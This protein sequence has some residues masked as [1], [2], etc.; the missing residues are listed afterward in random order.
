MIRILA[1]NHE[2]P[3]IQ[4]IDAQLAKHDTVGNWNCIELM[5]SKSASLLHPILKVRIAQRMFSFVDRL[6]RA[7]YQEA[8]W[9]DLTN[10]EQEGWVGRIDLQLKLVSWQYLKSHQSYILIPT[11]R[12]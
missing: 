4:Q 3:V 6:I 11:H 1:G 7:L 5:N 2:S 8:I 12:A 10:H 9:S